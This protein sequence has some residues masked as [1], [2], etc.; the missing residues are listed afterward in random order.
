MITVFHILTVPSTLIADV[1]PPALAGRWHSPTCTQGPF[2]VTSATAAPPATDLHLHWPYLLDL[3]FAH[4]L[5]SSK[6]VSSNHIS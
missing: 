1:Y 4:M 2:P 5:P 3:T 6:M